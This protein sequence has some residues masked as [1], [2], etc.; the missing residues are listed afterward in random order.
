MRR[1]PLAIT[2]IA[3]TLAVASCSKDTKTG[4]TA[5]DESKGGPSVVLL[6][7]EKTISTGSSKIAM[8]AGFD[9][10][11]QS[12]QMTGEGAFDYVAQA[13]SLAFKVSGDEI[14]E[15]FSGFEIRFIKDTLYMKFPKEFRQLAPGLK[16][17]V[18]ADL[19]EMAKQ[20]GVNLPGLNSFAGQDPTSALNFTRGATDVT[21]VGAEQVR[22]ARTTR[23][24][25]TVDLKKA[26]AAFPEDARGGFE[27]MFDDAGITELPMELW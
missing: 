22:G 1:R 15:A 13:G 25:M 12:F 11:G 7:A 23:F 9:A 19:K 27:K 21:E 20:Q 8:A 6:A 18:R 14:P 10:A 16:Q 26:I 3:L 24:S 5:K 2:V 4:S 17:W